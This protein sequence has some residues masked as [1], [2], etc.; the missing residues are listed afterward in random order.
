MTLKTRA[1][2]GPFSLLARFSLSWVRGLIPSMGNVLG[3]RQ[4][5]DDTVQDRLNPLVLQGRAAVDRYAL[6]GQGGLPDGGDK[7]PVGDL[8]PRQVP[9]RHVVVQLG[10]G[11]DEGFTPLVRLVPEF[12]RDVPIAHRASERSVV[13][14]NQFLSQ[15]VHRP[16]VFPVPETGDL[17][18]ERGGVEALPHHV[19]GAEIFGAHAIHLVDEGDL[20]NPVLVRLVPDRFRLG[21][22]AAHGVED[23]DGAVENPEGPFHLDGEIHVARRVYDVYFVIFPLAGRHG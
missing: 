10:E 5:I 19:D 12:G 17:D 1:A 4:K 23:D 14:E 7:I 8:L 3:R 9:V 13:P 15:E 6:E 11:L 22:H 16:D 20:G 2:R 18:D 21:F